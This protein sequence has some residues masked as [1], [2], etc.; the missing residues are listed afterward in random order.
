MRR[1]ALRYQR[2]VM[3][4]VASALGGLPRGISIALFIDI[5]KYEAHIAVSQHTRQALVTK[6]RTS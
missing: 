6:G 5:K 2:S 1:N 4:E 3:A